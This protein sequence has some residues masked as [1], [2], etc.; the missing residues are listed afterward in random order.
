MIE[1]KGLN[2]LHRDLRQKMK[3]MGAKQVL[4]LTAWRGCGEGKSPL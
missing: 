1:I 2:E 3:K 4:V